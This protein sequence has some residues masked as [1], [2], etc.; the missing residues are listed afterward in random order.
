VSTDFD[1]STRLYFEP[2]TLEDVLSVLRR[3]NAKGVV[4]Q[5]GGQTS[6]SLAVPLERAIK[7]A[8][9]PTQILGTSAD[10]MDICEDRERFAKVL[11]ELH[12]PYPSA[13]SARSVEEARKVAER[14][15]YPLLVRPSYVLGGRAMRVVFG[16]DELDEYMRSAV[17]V[18]KEH[19]VLLDR[20]LDH[21]IEV[22][23]DAVADGKSVLI[24]GIMEHVEEAG[25]HSGDSTCFL[26]PQ[27]LKPE[28]VDTIALYMRKIA[29]RLQV[30]GLINIQFAV[31]DDEVYV[32]EANP[33][34]SRTVPFV[35][36]SVGI[37]LAKVA[38]RVILGERLADMGIPL[39]P[40]VPRVACKAP[41]FPFQKLIGLDAILGPE[42]KSTGE[43]MGIASDAGVA[44][45]KAMTA[46][47]APLPQKG[48]VYITVR[49]DDKQRILPVVR[50]LVKSGFTIVATRG[51]AEYLRDFD[52]PCTTVWRISE[53]R[54]PDAIDLMRRGEVQ[55]IINTP[56]RGRGPR[57]DAFGMRRLAVELGIPFITTIEAARAAARAIRSRGEAWGAEPLGDVHQRAR[58]TWEAKPR[59]GNT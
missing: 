34:S 35:S 18:S 36:K 46:A 42:M 7:E 52:V 17:K 37:P 47:G 24:G 12:I 58:D 10:A 30:K 40:P 8:G 48:T 15:G 54:S 21:A 29:L 11:D 27:S 38:A 19:P 25:I 23:V 4:L 2:L 49:D 50:S 44:Y 57:S 5:F 13:G 20:F 39:D 26:P 55:L 53:N 16:H 41:V 14:I 59:A 9:L 3:E 56:G 32:L 1:T 33:R 43:V 31:K 28:V 45:D 6:V 51:T 22:D